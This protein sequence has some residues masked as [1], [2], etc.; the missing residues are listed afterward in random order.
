[1]SADDT[2]AGE[3]FVADRDEPET[4]RAAG[5]ERTQRLL[6]G[7]FAF[8]PPLSPADIAWYYDDNP[9]GRA[10]IGRVERDGQRLG[11]YALIPLEAASGDGACV[12]LGVGVDLAVAA[13]ARGSGTFRAT[14]EDAYRRGAA[15]GLDAILGVAN[16]NSAPRMVQALGWR[17][18]PD[19]PVRLVAPGPGRSAYR[20]R[21]VDPAFLA[22][23]EFSSVVGEAFAAPTSR[24]FTPRWTPDYLRWRL[25][26]RRATY[27]L[28]AD[29]RLVAVSTV[30][31][32]KG[33]PF[34]VLLKTLPRSDATGAVAGGPLVGHLARTHRTPFVVHFGRS[35]RVA[36]HGVTLPRRLLPSPLALVLH[37]LHG[38]FDEAGFRLDALEFLDFDGY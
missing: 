21:R 26:K 35:P 10:P 12:R 7:V 9:L 34:A 22:S 33:V 24:G 28:H 4:D 8:E 31:R 2:A 27:W 19:L 11:N 14:V 25:A 5:H 6:S 38:G 15:A 13:D 16:A 17:A 1:V 18:L 23:A 30:T 20:S 37:G 36:L 29:D 32:M 3:P